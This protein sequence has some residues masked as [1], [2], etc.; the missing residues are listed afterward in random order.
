LR[1]AYEQAVL[2]ILARRWRA[3]LAF[4]P[5]N[6]MSLGVATLSIPS[7][8]T[9]HDASPQYYQK[10]LP[11]YEPS[12]VLNLRAILA[13]WAARTATQIVADSEFGRSEILRTAGV[14][15]D[16]VAVVYLG[17]TEARGGLTEPLEVFKRFGISK[18]YIL[19]VGRVQKHKNFDR[20]VRALAA[21]KKAMNFPHQLVI[22]GHAGT[23]QA[24]IETTIRS[25][26]ARDYVRLTGFLQ[27]TELA[28]LYKEADVFA[29][30]SL[31]EGFGLPVLEAMRA[32][33]PVIASAVCSLPEVSGN[34][35]LFCDPWDEASICKALCEIILNKERAMELAR[36]G[37]VHAGTFTWERTAAEMLEIFRAVGHRNESNTRRS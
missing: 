34:A 27:D 3:D 7:V 8:V 10:S 13:K 20:L 33:V 24:D 14:S 12:L 5:A 2:P 22:A 15:R 36:K 11:S 28:T 1:L 4:F 9:I 32:G 35:A 31:Y 19:A 18:P 29:M 21:A 37:R 26:G 6:M 17:S 25:D 23:G 16:K 30:P